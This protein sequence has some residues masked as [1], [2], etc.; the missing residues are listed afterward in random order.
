MLSPPLPPLPHKMPPSPPGCPTGPLAPSAPSPTSGRPSS[1]WVG[2]FT[3]FSRFCCALAIS[4]LAY[5][6]PP[7]LSSWTNRS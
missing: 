5:E 7:A 6:P 4:A 1:V 3:A 2:A